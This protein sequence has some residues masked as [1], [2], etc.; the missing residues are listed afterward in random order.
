MHEK[1]KISIMESATKVLSVK[2]YETN[3]SKQNWKTSIFVFENFLNVGA[4]NLFLQERLGTR[5]SSH[6]VLRH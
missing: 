5:L 1:V 2:C 6:E 4:I 3:Q